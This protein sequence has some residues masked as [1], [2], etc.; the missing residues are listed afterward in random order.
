MEIY[1]YTTVKVLTEAVISYRWNVYELKGSNTQDRRTKRIKSF[2]G[3]LQCS[4]KLL[5]ST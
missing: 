1:V 3:P 2:F 5:P 4:V